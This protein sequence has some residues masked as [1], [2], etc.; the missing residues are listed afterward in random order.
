MDVFNDKLSV[1]PSGNDGDTLNA[2][3]MLHLALQKMDGIIATNLDAESLSIKSDSLILSSEDV[4]YDISINTKPSIPISPIA[5]SNNNNNYGKVLN[6]NVENVFTLEIDNKNHEPHHKKQDKLNRLLQELKDYSKENDESNLNSNRESDHHN[7]KA[8][9]QSNTKLD[10]DTNG[11]PFQRNQRNPYSSN[12]N[13]SNHQNQTMDSNNHEVK[14]IDDVSTWTKKCFRGGER[15]TRPLSESIVSDDIGYNSLRQRSHSHSQQSLANKDYVYRQ[16]MSD[17]HPMDHVDIV[18]NMARYYHHQ[19]P[20]QQQQSVPK[21]LVH[22]PQ[23]MGPYGSYDPLGPIYMNH[24]QS[25]ANYHMMQSQPP[26]PPPPPPP[27]SQS[28]ANAYQRANY[29]SMCRT[30]GCDHCTLTNY[31]SNHAYDHHHHHPH[32]LMGPYWDYP[33]SLL[34]ASNPNLIGHQIG[35]ML[36]TGGGG[37]HHRKASINNNSNGSP[38]LT[39]SSSGSN[40]NNNSI[41]G[42]GSPSSSTNQVSIENMDNKPHH[43]HQH[44]NHN[45]HHHHP[46]HN[47]PMDNKSTTPTSTPEYYRHSPELMT[48]ISTASAAEQDQRNSNYLQQLGLSSNTEQVHYHEH[49]T[50]TMERCA[51]LESIVAILRNQLLTTEDLFKKALLSKKTLEGA[52]CDLLTIVDKLK[53]DLTHSEGKRKLVEDHNTRIEADIETI[54]TRLLEKETEISSLRLTLAKIVRSTG[55]VLSDNEL[56]LLRGKTI[57]SDFIKDK[58]AKDNYAELTYKSSAHKSGNAFYSEPSSRRESYSSNNGPNGQSSPIVPIRY[59]SAHPSPSSTPPFRQGKN[60]TNGTTLPIVNSNTMP[61]RS[62]SA[63]NVKMNSDEHNGSNDSSSNVINMDNHRARS[64]DKQNSFRF[65]NSYST[66]PHNARALRQIQQQLNDGECESQ[67][68]RENEFRQMSQSFIDDQLTTNDKPSERIPSISMPSSP[69]IHFKSSAHGQPSAKDEEIIP[70]SMQSSASELNRNGV[71]QQ[72]QP[73]SST[74]IQTSKAKGF[75][76]IFSSLNLPFSKWD[77]N[78]VADWFALIGLGM[79]ANECKRWCKNGEHLMRAT[80]ADV[81]KDLGIKNALHRKKLRLAVAA[82]NDEE[83]TML[84]NAGR[85]DYLWVARWLDDIGLPQYKDAF[86]DARIDGRVLHYLTIEDLF[87]LKVVS[88][89]HFASIRAGVRILRENNYN[90]QCLKRRATPEESHDGEWSP[91]EVALWSSHRVMEWLR[92]I[93]LSEYAPNLRGS[94]VHGALILFENAFN[95]DLFATLLSIPNTKTLLRRHISAKFKQL[96]GE[97]LNK[98]KRDFE[99]QPNYSPMIPG[100]KIKAYKKGHFSLMRKKRSDFELTDYVCPMSPVP[101]TRTKI[102]NML[103]G[104]KNI[105]ITNQSNVANNMVDNDL[106]KNSSKSITTQFEKPTK[107][108]NDELTSKSDSE[109]EETKSMN[110]LT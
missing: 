31:M 21:H 43:H 36:S 51:Q 41:S 61:S 92:S 70:I 53:L 16:S 69:I 33:T 7:Q 47:S 60:G 99:L 18:R 39:P 102:M 2:S 48:D 65:K 6:R 108:I 13:I 34:M 37:Q 86:V 45:H 44:P 110:N 12:G 11:L 85:L 20:Q 56:A 3:Q 97:E 62:T 67:R 49:A 107:S 35:S 78:L 73:Q 27:P 32:H 82:M 46:Q 94:G 80:S 87:N 68:K 38:N 95:A 101:S 25:M 14:T 42:N 106:L 103:H 88:Q 84:K 90:S 15:I 109:L 89:L 52:N 91:G 5:N 26:P 1:N 40:N 4:R 71:C 59:H 50:S 58:L 19:Q 105:P 81:E 75:R 63:E 17:Y 72:S 96:I 98:M 100:S 9:K 76:R 64:E 54:K 83:D 30:I 66:M 28:T 24:H 77:T 23:Y 8:I 57:A 55:Y 74:L 29:A 79:Y 10:N 104:S 22:T 93:D